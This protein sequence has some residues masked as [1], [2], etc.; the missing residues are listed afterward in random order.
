MGK[1]RDP[2]VEQIITGEIIF[3]MSN[4]NQYGAIR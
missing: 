3:I 4:P 2:E 1:K